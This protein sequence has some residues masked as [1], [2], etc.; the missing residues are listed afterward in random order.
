MG[1]NRFPH[2]PRQG[3]PA[4][5][6][7]IFLLLRRSE[8]NAGLGV[9]HGDIW[10]N[11]HG[12]Q[13]HIRLPWFFR[14]ENVERNS[15][16]LE[17]GLHVAASGHDH[18]ILLVEDDDAARRAFERANPPGHIHRH[19]LPALRDPTI[20]SQP[21]RLMVSSAALNTAE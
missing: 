1:Q 13:N 10:R 4:F 19:Q 11:G 8:T 17:Q 2:L 6:S 16:Q 5:A 7:I 9:S 18:Q 12:K 20:R 21:R 15:L 14:G 3:K